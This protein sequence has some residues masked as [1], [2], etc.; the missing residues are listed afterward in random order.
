MQE[1]SAKKERKFQAGFDRIFETPVRSKISS[2]FSV[3]S[4]QPIEFH[5]HPAIEAFLVEC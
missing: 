3:V 4:S 2:Q 1:A 5:L